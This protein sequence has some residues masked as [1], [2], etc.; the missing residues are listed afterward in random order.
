MRK[1]G[2]QIARAT[3][4]LLLL[5]HRLYQAQEPRAGAGGNGRKLILKT[6]RRAVFGSAPF[7]VWFFQ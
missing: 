5:G 6:K 7:F 1:D 3:L 4:D 2:G